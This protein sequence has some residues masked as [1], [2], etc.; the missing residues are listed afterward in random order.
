MNTKLHID[1]SFQAMHQALEEANQAFES[2]GADRH[3]DALQRLGRAVMN[4]LA[5]IIE[6]DGGTDGYLYDAEGIAQDIEACYQ[7]L[8]E[9]EDAAEP[10]DVPR[11]AS[12]GTLNFRQQGVAR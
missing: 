6:T 8:V 9:E 1:G 3:R 10:H 7:K 12:H 5:E 2:G 11:Q 4:S